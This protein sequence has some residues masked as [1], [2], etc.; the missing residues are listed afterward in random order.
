LFCLRAHNVTQNHYNF[1]VQKISLCFG[2][3]VTVTQEFRGFTLVT[4]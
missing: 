1:M 2:L 4:L 3:Q